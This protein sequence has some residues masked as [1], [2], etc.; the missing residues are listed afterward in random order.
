V[1]RR[2]T[3]AVAG[4]GHVLLVS[5]AAP[6]PWARSHDHGEHHFPTPAD[7]LGDL[8]L[9]PAGWDV[10]VNEVRQR[11]ATGPDGE[12]ATLDDTVTFARRRGGR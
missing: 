2:A 7:D 6:P 3:A 8:G 1:L 11:D 5:H 10:L 12:R 4:G 9:D